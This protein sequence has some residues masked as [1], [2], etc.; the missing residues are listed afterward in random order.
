MKFKILIVLSLFALNSFSQEDLEDIFDDGVANPDWT[1][2]VGLDAATLIGGTVHLN[3][4]I[5]FKDK[6]GLQVG[7]G[8]LPFGY[9]LDVSSPFGVLDDDEDRQARYDINGGTHMNLA[10]K[11]VKSYSDTYK[12]YFYGMYKGWKFSRTEKVIPVDPFNPTSKTLNID[13]KR[14]KYNI[15]S[16]ITL[17]PFDHIGFDLRGGVYLG[18]NKFDDG[19]TNYP[20][21]AIFNGF[22]VGLGVFYQF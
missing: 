13:V 4:N 15:G 5:Y 20:R 1:I 14:R 3:G 22:D 12:W 11:Y 19:E 7:L 6:A 18:S 8:F 16:G 10:F 2:N 9:I 21:T 17:T